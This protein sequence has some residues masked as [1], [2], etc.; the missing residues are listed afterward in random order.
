MGKSDWLK[1]RNRSIFMTPR[2]I[3][4]ANL[5]VEQLAKDLHD[6]SVSMLCFF[7]GGYITN[8]PSELPLVRKAPMLGNRD[9]TA[10]IIQAIHKYDIKAV[11][12]LEL[13]VIPGTTARLHPDWC[14]IDINGN[15]YQLPGDLFTTCLMGGY[16]SDYGF[17]MAR[18]IIT[19]YDVD[20]MQLNSFGFQSYGSKVCYCENCREDF[21]KTYGAEIP[22]VVDWNDPNYRKFFR[23]R[24][25]KVNEGAERMRNM[26][27]DVNPDIPFTGNASCFG[28]P[29]WIARSSIDK[30]GVAEFEDIVKVEAQKRLT[31][32]EAKD[33]V[34]W[35]W[36]LWPAEEANYLTA[37]TDDKPVYVICSY[38]I[39]P[40]RRSAVPPVEQKAYLAQI[41]AHGGWPGVNL[42]GGPPATHNDKRGFQAIKELYGFLKA[43]N[44]FYENDRSA[45]RIAIVYSQHT[46]IFYGQD[47]ALPNYVE[48]IR[49]V[50]Q[51]LQDAHMPYDIIS[52]RTLLNAA[53]M[54][55]YKTIILPAMACMSE[56]EAAAIREYVQGGGGVVATFETSLYDTE[57]YIRDN[58]L[59]HDLFG[60]NYKGQTLPM[61]GEENDKNNLRTQSYIRIVDR[62]PI[63]KGLDE[64][65]LVLLPG[66][67]CS[68]DYDH[69]LETP[70]MRNPPFQAMPE[71]FAYTLEELPDEP[72]A[73]LSQQGNGGRVVY[74]SGQPDK[75]FWKIAYPDLGALIVNAVNWTLHEEE[76]EI[77]IDAPVTLY[78]AFRV[79]GDRKLLHLINL[80]SGRRFFTEVVPLYNTAIKLKTDALPQPVQKI[81]LVSDR[82]P[83][84]FNEENGYYSVVVPKLTDY[85]ILVFE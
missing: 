42:S 10:E 32:N 14:A 57:G 53:K 11:A 69:G 44:E 71:G 62:H 8:Y 36:M 76:P 66:K 35:Q 49:G 70:L 61:I 85:D 63:A 19:R 40:W 43:H 3:D 2:D 52:N 64:T 7:S 16:Y 6:M 80:T 26:V 21:R 46:M 17:K 1:T 67:Y 15:P 5:D 37:V 25:A 29:E 59:L 34:H 9:L 48:A 75:Y 74:F 33:E 72:M 27:K 56:E 47:K 81:F 55:K 84:P 82:E 39:G 45:A 38:F 31:L 30:E 13:A 28:D 77:V 4:V 24:E 22:R 79:Q 20:G 51:S 41:A 23:W 73:L 58:F 78:T 60:A 54:A 83:L 12:G 65:D 50:E 18:E 68:I